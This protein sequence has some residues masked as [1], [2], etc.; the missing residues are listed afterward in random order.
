MP[1]TSYYNKTSVPDTVNEMNESVIVH[2]VR[3]VARYLRMGGQE[4][5]SVNLIRIT[6]YYSLCG[7]GR[8]LG[9]VQ[10]ALL[11]SWNLERSFTNALLPDPDAL[12]CLEMA[13]HMAVIVCQYSALV[14]LSDE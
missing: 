13:L 10:I 7:H 11:S 3:G 1:S 9:L 5:E 6:D 14:K 12:H 8:K 2:S 4:W